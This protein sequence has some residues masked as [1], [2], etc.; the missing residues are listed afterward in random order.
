MKEFELSSDLFSCID[1]TMYES[2]LDSRNVLENEGCDDSI[3]AFEYQDIDCK[4]WEDIVL[5]S[6]ISWMESEVLPVMEKY[7]VER[8]SDYSLHHP[9][10]YNFATDRLY[11]TVH[12]KEGWER[13]MA[14]WL[15]E[16]RRNPMFQKF[17]NDNYTS[18]S[19]FISFMPQSLDEIERMEDEER[20]MG[21]YLTLAYLS[22]VLPYDFT[23][24]C[25]TSVFLHNS[26][27]YIYEHAIE[28]PHFEIEAHN[29]LVEIFPEG[30]DDLSDLYEHDDE[31]NDL[32]HDVAAKIGH[33]WKNYRI[34]DC[35]CGERLDGEIKICNDAMAFLYWAACQ[36]HTVDDL[37]A[38]AC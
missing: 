9:R 32:Y 30:G 12:M 24:N 25:E 20:C 22:D 27:D 16:F 35:V 28:S 26:M 36:K 15:S 38:I 4:K 34:G 13:T 8:F 37:R 14:H 11:F 5:G 33:R 21:A 7:G 23:D 31:L 19:G 2:E 3:G 6:A 17:I 18:R 29:V 1:V 10:E